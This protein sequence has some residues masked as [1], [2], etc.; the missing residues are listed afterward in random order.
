MPRTANSDFSKD[1]DKLKTNLAEV[2]TAALQAVIDQ[3]EN[4][5]PNQEAQQTIAQLNTNRKPR[6]KQVP[7]ILLTLA[8]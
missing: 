6:E 3:V 8:K 7:Q 1:N 5:C 4:V 2:A